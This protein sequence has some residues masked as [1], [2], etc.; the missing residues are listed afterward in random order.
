MIYDIA[1]E[2][3]YNALH[4]ATERLRAEKYVRVLAHYDGDGVS[5]SIILL[6]MLERLDIKYH[7][8]YI[9][10]LDNEGFRVLYEEEANAL[11]IIVDAGSSQIPAIAGHTNFIVL[12]HHFYNKAETSGIN[13][14]ARDYGINGTREACGSTMAYMFALVMDEKNRDL[15]PFFM[16]GVMADKQD[17]GGLSGINRKLFDEYNSYQTHHTLN[18]EGNLLDA[19]TY[20]IDPFF[21][22]LT[23]HPDAVKEFLGKIN[24]SQEKNVIDL[25]TDENK[26]LANML[27]LKILENGVGSDAIKYLEGDV[28]Y[29]DDIGF[30]SKELNSII[31]GNA[32]IGMQS[33]PVQ[34][35]LGD[36]SVSAEMIGNAKIFKTKLIDYIYRAESDLKEEKYL[37]YF[38]APESE[39]AGPISGAIALYTVKPDK[40]VIG[41][42]VG[43]D[44]IKISSR[45]SRQAV[46]KGLNLSEV[47][48]AACAAAGGSGGG[49]DIAAG[50]VIPRGREK[51]F[52]DAAGEVIKSQI[53]IP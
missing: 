37:R 33:L 44:D 25:T 28:L 43:T 52:L 9:K 1:G 31:D 47:M 24:I 21:P 40:P 38:Y 34:Y 49:H 51:Q 22:G 30:S 20:S 3:L 16:S 48:K 26:I 8:S 4:D 14:N 32:R 2:D 41:F 11:N 6:G 36:S 5:S 17:I 19:I 35:F 15:F 39:M 7:L 10:N 23:G 13:I 50:G 27:A 42:N 18:M 46:S 45:G 12:D 29:F 53:K